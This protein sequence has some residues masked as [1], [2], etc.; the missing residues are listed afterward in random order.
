MSTRNKQKRVGTVYST[1]PDFQYE[2]EKQSEPDTLPAAQ[3]NL[4]VRRDRK[5]RAGKVVTIVNGFVGRTEDLKAL[6][7]ALKSACGV[8]GTVKA[9]EILIQGDFRD[10]VV[11]L[12]KSKGYPAKPSG[13]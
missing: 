5:G 4:R 13:G 11:A 12:L 6:G 7:K 2:H 10:R 8:G 9:G 3:Q 1:D